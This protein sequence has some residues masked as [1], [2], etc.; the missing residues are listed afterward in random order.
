[1]GAVVTS[2]RTGAR[3]APAHLRRTMSDQTLPR[4]L[5]PSSTRAPSPF[6]L[7]FIDADRP[8]NPVYLAAALQLTRPGAVIVIDNVVRGGMI[9]LRRR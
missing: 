9:V 8:S 6:D 4:R 1:M 3:G 7:V 2:L 5:R